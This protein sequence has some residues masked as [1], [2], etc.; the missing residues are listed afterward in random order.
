MWNLSNNTKAILYS[1][2][3]GVVLIAG[4]MLIPSNHK[5]GLIVSL[6]ALIPQFIAHTY[7]RK[8]MAEE[9]GD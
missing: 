8:A 7:T 9:N 4:I 6:S 2:L 3:Q 1:L 5:L